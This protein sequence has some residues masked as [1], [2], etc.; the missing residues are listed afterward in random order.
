MWDMIWSSG[1]DV[2]LRFTK[3]VFSPK[4]PRTSL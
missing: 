1:L 4:M 2:M 3:Q